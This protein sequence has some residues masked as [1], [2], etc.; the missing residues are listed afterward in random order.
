[1]HAVDEASKLFLI[2]DEPAVRRGGEQALR[3]ADIPVRS[4]ADAESALAVINSTQA[5]LPCAVVC[6]VRL[7]GIDGMSL[8]KYLQQRDAEL[9]VILMTG[10]GDIAMAVQAMREGAYDFLEK[11]FS[12]DRLVEVV[13]RARD[14]R[15]LVVENRRLREVLQAGCTAS[16]IGE[17]TAIEAVRRLVAALAPA[18]VD[19][20]INGETGSGKEVLARAIHSASG[21]QGLF[22]AVNC[23]ALPESVFE[24]EI[25][26]HEAGSFTG[27]GKRRIGKI[28]HAQGGTLFLDEIESMPLNLQVKLLRVLQER[29]VERLGGNQRIPVDLRVVAASKADLKI[30]AEAGRFRA[31]LYY[32]LNV[33]AIDLPPLRARREDIPLLLAHF[34]RLA[35]ARYGRPVRE[36][37]TVDVAR[38]HEY[39][40]P[41]NVRELKNVADRLCLGLDDGLPGNA[42]PQAGATETQSPSLAERVDAVEKQYIETALEASRG[43]VQGAADLLQLPK[44]TLHDKLHRYAIDPERFRKP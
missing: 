41:G 33:V 24:S 14:K 25:F 34:Q 30:E 12:S 16:L 39:E 20:L 17:S 40:W 36:L 38:W 22:V 3:L 37:S 7:P 26:G 42:A 31:D 2:E 6:D 5:E 29:E 44:R 19:I 15:A 28:E 10:H 9:P 13:Q 4:F 43:Q 11:P 27:A 32:R 8:L 18:G 1:M 35:A 23:G 21:R